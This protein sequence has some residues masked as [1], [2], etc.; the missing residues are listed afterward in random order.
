MN[1][2]ISAA[3]QMPASL[4]VEHEQRSRYCAD[5]GYTRGD[6]G[7][8]IVGL[9]NHRPNAGAL[10]VADFVADTVAWVVMDPAEVQE[11]FHDYCRLATSDRGG[12]STIG[13]WGWGH[14][15]L[16]KVPG[17]GAG[18]DIQVQSKG[19]PD[20]R[21][22]IGDELLPYLWYDLGWLANEVAS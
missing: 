22:A 17:P 14:I 10:L 6:G 12:Q 3:D 18:L 16:S 5:G 19:H 8:V 7:Q 21:V 11:L 20:T 13:V 15:L 4:F 2:Q 1:D 9:V